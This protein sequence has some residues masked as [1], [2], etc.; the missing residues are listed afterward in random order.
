MGT[1]VTRSVEHGGRWQSEQLWRQGRAREWSS[2]TLRIT[3]AVVGGFLTLL[4]LFLLVGFGAA[5]GD[6]WTDADDRWLALA[7]VLFAMAV[8]G[9]LWWLAAHYVFW[10]LP[11]TRERDATGRSASGRA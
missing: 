1:T 11:A 6:V 4:T 3:A 5:V 7:G 10:R 2:I 9:G 8:T